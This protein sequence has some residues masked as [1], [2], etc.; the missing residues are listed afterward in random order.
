MSEQSVKVTIQEAVKDAMR[1]KD[2]EKLSVMRT[3]LAEFKQ[4]EIDERIELSRTQELAVLDK[5]I[6]QRK[7]AQAQF[8]QGNRPELAEKEELEIKIIELFKPEPLSDKAVEAE[9]QHAIQT[10]GAVDIKD[11]SKVIALLKPKL[12]GMADMS[13]VSA[14]VKAILSKG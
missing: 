11:M 14:Q 5:M 9:I 13:K 3:I 2:R 4:I 6:K 8:I 1:A 12:Q 7:E 10:V